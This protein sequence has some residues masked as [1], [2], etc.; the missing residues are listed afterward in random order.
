MSAAVAHRDIDGHPLHV[1]GARDGRAQVLAH[2]LGQQGQVADDRQLPAPLVGQ[3]RHSLADDAQQL[4]QLARVA[5]EIVSGK[6]PQR[7][8]GDARVL[9]PL[10]ELGDLARARAVPLRGGRAQRLGPAAVP[11][12]DDSHVLGYCRVGQLGFEATLVHVVE[13]VPL[14]H[15]VSP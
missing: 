11:V 8:D 7:H 2:L 1:R 12:E 15:V 13:H 10:E 9:R 14:A 5:R 3:E 4:A 6:Q